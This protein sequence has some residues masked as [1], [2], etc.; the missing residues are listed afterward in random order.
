[1]KNLRTIRLTQRDWTGDGIVTVVAGALVAV[2]V[3]LPWAND[4]VPVMR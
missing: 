4:R 3:L 1:M 2:A